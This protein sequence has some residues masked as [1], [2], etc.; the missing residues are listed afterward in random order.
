[1]KLKSIK[2]SAF[3]NSV[4]GICLGVITGTAMSLSVQA[5]TN[6]VDEYN[7]TEIIQQKQPSPQ[8]FERSQ[9]I[10]QANEFF[11]QEKFAE[12]Q[13]NLRRLMK[14][15]PDDPYPHYQLGNILLRQGQPE[16]AIAAYQEAIRRNSRHAL[17]RNGIGVARASQGLWDEAISEYQQALKINSN[18]GD[19]LAN[20]G[21]ALIRKGKKQEGIASLEKAKK[22]YQQQ[23]RP[24]KVKQVEEFLQK[25]NQEDSTTVSMRG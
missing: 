23:D 12:A 13:N 9:L 11:A 15:F 14:M 17:A 22:V 6:S 5:Q 8:E 16:A 20:L 7:P 10:R 4:T 25:L 19:A 24:E 1:M 3:V 18:Y 21:E 2:L